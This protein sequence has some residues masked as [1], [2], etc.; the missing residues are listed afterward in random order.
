MKCREVNQLFEAYLDNEINPS[1]RMLI[2]SH[3]AGCETCQ[4]ELAALSEN[5]NRLS[6]YLKNRAAQASPSPQALSR[7]QERLTDDAQR[8]SRRLIPWLRRSALDASHNNHSI[9]GVLSMK[10]KLSF[11]VLAVVLLLAATVAFVP[12]VRAEVERI[13]IVMTTGYSTLSEPMPLDTTD[14]G[15]LD[16]FEGFPIAGGGTVA[17]SAIENGEPVTSTSIYQKDDKFLVFT[18]SMTETGE[19]LPD[20]ETIRVN[21]MPGV[22]NTGLS[23]EYRQ[24]APAGIDQDNQPV[25]IEP[26]IIT[27]TDANRLTWMDGNTI[28]EILSNLPVDVMLEI[29]AQLVLV[30]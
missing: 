7:L 13:L 10:T 11:A 6:H 9:K 1:E 29:A 17:V 24:D 23:G 22:L 19:E 27:Y 26:V 21:D 25:E 16:E 8:P 5:R 2:H 30:P 3:L 20:G 28:Y 14:P 15:Y 18:R 12:A 4:R